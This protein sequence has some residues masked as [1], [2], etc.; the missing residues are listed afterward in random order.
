MMLYTLL[1]INNFYFIAVMALVH[2][3]DIFTSVKDLLTSSTLKW[4]KI[5]SSVK[6]KRFKQHDE[7]LS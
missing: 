7:H 6:T 4:T 2:H 5:H 3:V 1:L